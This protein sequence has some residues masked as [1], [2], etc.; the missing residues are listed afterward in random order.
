[1]NISESINNNIPADKS[2]HIFYIITEALTNIKKHAQA[3]N[4]SLSL[5]YDALNELSIKIK[6]DGIGFDC[7]EAGLS[8]SACGKWGL[9]SMHQRVA[10]LGGSLAINSIPK[11]GT[12][13]LV[14]IPF[15]RIEYSI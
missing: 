11:Q 5:D 2:T 15:R 3:K 4:V 6:D 12:E 9:M 8:A 10:S 7:R 14:M 1:L 13:I